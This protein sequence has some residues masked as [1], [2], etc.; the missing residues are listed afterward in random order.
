V[1]GLHAP[2]R[3]EN[4]DFHVRVARPHVKTNFRVRALKP[5]A[6]RKKKKQKKKEKRNPNPN[7][8]PSSRGPPL[9]PSRSPAAAVALAVAHRRTHLTSQ[10]H[11]S[12]EASHINKNTSHEHISY[13]QITHKKHK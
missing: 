1:G 11:T 6:W 2:S 4:H 8:P 5:S 13:E 9:S 7:P 12:Q 10:E 3:L